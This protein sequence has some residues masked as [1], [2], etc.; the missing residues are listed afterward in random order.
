MKPI[1]I[2][3]IAVVLLIPLSISAQST[4]DIP[5]WVKTNAVW[6]GEGQISDSEFLSAL[7]YLITNGHLRVDTSDTDVLEDKIKN[8]E[9]ENREL[10]N[11]IRYL[12]AEEKRLRTIIDNIN[13][14]PNI[15][16]EQ[17]DISQ[18]TIQ[19]LKEQSV[20]WNY[21]DILRNEEYYKGK[22]IYLEAKISTIMEDEEYG[23]WVLLYVYTADGTYIDWIE[24]PMY[25]WY[26]G[27]RLLNG[28]MIQ[29]Y[30]VVDGLHAVESMIEGS[31][32]YYPIGTAMYVTCTS[33]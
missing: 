13:S 6:W 26:D 29:T 1:I 23:D 4:M 3:A 17:I 11:D 9:N 21:K 15:V 27:S 12:E 10:E 19:E 7:Q 31:Y 14:K 33:C 16:E 2:I 5:S 25:I 18:L 24:D 20:T 30:I 22:I 28:D 8:L 32:I